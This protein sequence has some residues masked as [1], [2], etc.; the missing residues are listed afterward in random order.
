MSRIKN[1]L[2]KEFA[3]KKYNV[4]INNALLKLVDINNKILNKKCEQVNDFNNVKSDINNIILVIKNINCY[5]L[6]ANQLGIDKSIICLYDSLEKNNILIFINPNIIIKSEEKYIAS[7]GSVS[8]P[9]YNVEIERSESIMLEY[10]TE[11]NERRVEKFS[12]FLSQNIQ[13]QVDTVN[14]ENKIFNKYFNEQRKITTENIINIGGGNK[15][16]INQEE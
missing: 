6:S 13:H 4:K 10:F 8:L 16:I 3:L 12:G 7:E 11:N 5:G 1:K 15:K 9:N 14:G 2:K